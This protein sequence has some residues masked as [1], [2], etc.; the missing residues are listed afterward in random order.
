[1]KFYRLRWVLN[2]FLLNTKLQ[3]MRLFMKTQKIPHHILSKYT[4][5]G[6]LQY[7]KNVFD[8]TATKGSCEYL[9]D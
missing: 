1:M 3:K 2:K 4:N 7:F 5:C 6:T 8:F 9:I